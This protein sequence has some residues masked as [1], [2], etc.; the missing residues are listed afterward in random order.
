MEW[1]GEAEDVGILIPYR[2]RLYSCIRVRFVGVDK[3]GQRFTNYALLQAG[4]LD[5]VLFDLLRKVRA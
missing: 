5:S 3:E 1:Q 2:N 4:Q